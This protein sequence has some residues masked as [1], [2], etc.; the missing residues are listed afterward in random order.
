MKVGTMGAVGTAAI[1]IFRNAEEKVR[2]GRE[3]QDGENLKSDYLRSGSFRTIIP[4]S[5]DVLLSYL[6]N[7]DLILR[8]LPR[9]TPRFL[10]L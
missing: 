10:V 7:D 6:F 9:G 5:V 2:N 8:V 3:S 1:L 4:E